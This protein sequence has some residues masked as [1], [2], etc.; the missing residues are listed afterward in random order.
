MFGKV[1]DRVLKVG[2]NRFSGLSWGLQDEQPSQ[3][4]VLQRAAIKAQKKADTLARSLKL[5]LVRIMD[6]QEG[7]VSVAAPAGR[8]QMARLAMAH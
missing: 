5:L 6:V 7:R 4:Q 3:L 1:V 8:Y 2:A